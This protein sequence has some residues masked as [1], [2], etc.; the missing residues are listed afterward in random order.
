MILEYKD[1]DSGKWTRLVEW[2]GLFDEIPYQGQV[3]REIRMYNDSHRPAEKLTLTT[4][5]PL[6]HNLP[7]E[8][9]AGKKT[10]FTMTL[11][12]QDLYEMSHTPK[13]T[14]KLKWNEVIRT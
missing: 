14:V 1:N 9:K 8:I 13:G 7:K 2:D 12:W 3:K 10:E 6:H 4:D 11:K 5:L